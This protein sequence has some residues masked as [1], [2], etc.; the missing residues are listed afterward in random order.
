MKKETQNKIDKIL[1]G[2]IQRLDKM[3]KFTLEQLPD[4][5]KEILELKKVQIIN[6]IIQYMA[7]T[8]SILFF[9]VFCV[10]MTFTYASENN[11]WLCLMMTAIILGIPFLITS[12]CLLENTLKLREL[13]A[14]PKLIILKE[15]RRLL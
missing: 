14:A 8:L 3:E 15:L 10:I 6:N 13:K 2:L 4:V 1:N 11:I 5:C 9:I 7:G 12:A